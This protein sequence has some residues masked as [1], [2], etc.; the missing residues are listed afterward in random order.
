MIHFA[1]R[2]VF[3]GDFF[4]SVVNS[5][6]IN[7]GIMLTFCL[8]LYLTLRSISQTVSILKGTYYNYVAGTTSL[9]CQS[10]SDY[11]SYFVKCL[12]LLSALCGVTTIY[13][14]EIRVIFSKKTHYMP[15]V[16]CTTSLNVFGQK[17]K[18]S[19]SILPWQNQI[20]HK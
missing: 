15:S 9:L 5:L 11:I 1:I 13:L 8:I 19:H 18:I 17:R 7:P 20:L 14:A 4:A 6:L 3:L 2:S 16:W 10:Y 12:I